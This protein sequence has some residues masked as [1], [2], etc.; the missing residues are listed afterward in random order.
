MN[1]PSYTF[2]DDLVTIEDSEA[3]K[4]NVQSCWSSPS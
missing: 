1:A 4:F 3:D 2:Y